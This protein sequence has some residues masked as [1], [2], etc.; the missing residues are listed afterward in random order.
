MVY[1]GMLYL[2]YLCCMLMVI[3]VGKYVLCEKL[4]GMNKVEG[5]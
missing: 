3:V 2:E 1:I 5:E 4:F